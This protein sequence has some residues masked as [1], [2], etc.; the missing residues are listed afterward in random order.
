[1]TDLYIKTDIT[2]LSHDLGHVTTLY[3]FSVGGVLPVIF[4]SIVC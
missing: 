4:S 2:I 1:V 3:I